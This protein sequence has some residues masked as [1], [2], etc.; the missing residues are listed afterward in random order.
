[1]I[2]TTQL[3]SET[4]TENLFFT[5]TLRICFLIGDLPHA[6]SL[7]CKHFLLPVVRH[8]DQFGLGA[9][10]SRGVGSSSR[11]VGRRAVAAFA[12][13]VVDGVWRG[14]GR[15]RRRGWHLLLLVFADG[16]ERNPGKCLYGGASLGSGTV[17]EC[18]ETPVELQTK[19]KGS[20]QYKSWR[21]DINCCFVN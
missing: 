20:G 5:T 9:V 6:P 1:M 11:A 8:Q 13:G 7:S 10:S 21:Q 15:G 3:V 4:P 18:L 16:A 19:V 2:K 17:Q 12:R 14:A